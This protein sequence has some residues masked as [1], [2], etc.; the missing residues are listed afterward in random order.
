LVVGCAAILRFW[1][2][3]NWDV[4]GSAPKDG[5]T[6]TVAITHVDAT[7]EQLILLLGTE[8]SETQLAQLSNEA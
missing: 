8:L 6:E 5:R 3:Q 1:R 7:K 4:V 2:A